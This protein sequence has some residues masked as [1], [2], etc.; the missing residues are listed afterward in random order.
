M[1]FI[2]LRMTGGRL[3]LSAD[4]G[5]GPASCT[6]SGTVNDGEWHMVIGEVSRRS[7]SL[8]LDGRT[9]DSVF[10]KGN[11][12]DVEDRLFLGG[13]PHTHSTR[14]INASSSFSGCVR[15]VSLNGAMLDLSS[16]ASQHDVT[17]C[18][19]NDQT[20]SYFNGSGYAALMRDG[21]KV[22]SDVSVAFE[23]RTSQSEAVLLGISS[24]KVDAI[25]LELIH[26]Q[27]VFNVN[28]GA[29]RVSVRSIGPLLCDGLWHHL[30]A[31]K[32]KHSLSLSV[33]GRSYS[34][35]NPY[36]QSTSAETNNPVY[37]GGF[38]VGVKQNCLSVSSRFSGCLRKL[39]LIKSHLNDAL[40][41]SS[42]H[43]LLGVTPNS[44]PVAKQHVAQL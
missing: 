34:T 5:R 13:L 20:G 10:I 14:R 25:G 44:C 35:P 37:L 36:P 41:L 6:S 27:V 22:G 33:D 30:V 7:V 1:D 31:K 24:A 40:E 32:T 43:F 11:Q 29:G 4:L 39:H 15:S 12:L 9:P 8:S 2:V 3:V 38:P 16:P 42:A 19:T 21:Y 28:N 17:S 26:G 23:F 18:F